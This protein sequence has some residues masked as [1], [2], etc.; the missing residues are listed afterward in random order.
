M[1]AVQRDWG[2]V[3]ADLRKEGTDLV[4]DLSLMEK[5]LAKHGSLR[6][7]LSSVVGVE[8]VDDA[9]HAIGWMTL[10]GAAW[11]GSLGIGAFRSHGSRGFRQF[12]VV[13]RNTPRGV[14]V[15]L[16]GATFDEFIVGCHNPEAV[17]AGLGFGGP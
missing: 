2:I 12:A 7:A 14:R 3:V 10:M 8:V 16:Q 9:K 5:V 1:P 15:R 4:L 13:H 17:V 11:P 6:V